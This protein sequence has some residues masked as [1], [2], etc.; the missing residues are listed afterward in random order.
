MK[1]V[2]MGSPG[3]GKGTY[4]QDLV[5]T[6]N[7]THIS[8]GDLFRENMKNE[9]DLG[10]QAHEYISQ[11]QL[12]PDKITIAMVKAK[13]SEIEGGFILDGFPRTVPQAEALAGVTNLDLVI[14]FKADDEVIISRLSGRI[15]CRGCGRIYHKVN[16]PPK[17]EGKCDYCPGEIYQRKDD[18]PEAVQARLSAYKEQASPLLTF[19]QEKG[20]LK[21]VTINEEYG[22]H[23]EE[24]LARI[25]AVIK[26]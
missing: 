2:V 10:H 26:G 1:I 19:Y 23:K 17:V 13:L 15:I 14:N 5:Q 9:T 25:M 11:G 18:M 3:V 24:I 7:L 20:L 22:G 4:T 16:I 21:D 6:L 12:V 8:S